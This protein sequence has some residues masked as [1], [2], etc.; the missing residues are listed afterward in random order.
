MAELGG[1]LY[2]GHHGAPEALVAELNHVHW[3]AIFLATAALGVFTLAVAAGALL[4]GVLPRWVAYTGF[5]AG[6][7]CIL[8]VPAAG[9]GLVNGA[10]LVW[11]AWFVGLAV[12]ALR[13]P[14][15]RPE[16]EPLSA[17]ALA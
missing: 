2:D 7:L 17:T 13:G 8:A 5:A 15:V 12:A 14:R 9:A 16:L 3:F 11:V 10:T 6:A 4:T 1:A